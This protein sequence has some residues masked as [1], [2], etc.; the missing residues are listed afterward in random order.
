MFLVS[1]TLEQASG[2]FYA[3][4]IKQTKTPHS[5]VN[6]EKQTAYAK[7]LQGPLQSILYPLRHLKHCESCDALKSAMAHRKKWV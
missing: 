5:L 3:L 4:K 6:G 2:I 1:F 7:V